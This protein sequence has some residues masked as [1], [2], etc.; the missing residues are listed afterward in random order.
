[1]GAEHERKPVVHGHSGG[2]ELAREVDPECPPSVRVFR[3]R[4]FG[5]DE[6]PRTIG[7]SHHDIIH[8]LGR[9]DSYVDYAVARSPR[10]Q[11]QHAT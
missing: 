11:I 8:R 5:L 10:T 7:H 9:F 3:K 6:S 4:E 2:L 1:M